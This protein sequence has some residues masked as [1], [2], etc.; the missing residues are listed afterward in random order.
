MGTVEP[1][2]DAEV[3]IL[4]SLKQR[5]QGKS[6]PGNTHMLPCALSNSNDDNTAIFFIL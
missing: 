1:P 4:G 6:Q 5:G 3:Q 2:Q